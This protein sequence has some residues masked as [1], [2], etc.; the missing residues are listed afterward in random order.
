VALSRDPQWLALRLVQLAVGVVLVLALFVA[1][2]VPFH[3]TDALVYGQASRAIAE[4]GGF[5]VDGVAY[6]AYSRPLFYVTQGWLWWLFGWQEWIGRL[7]SLAFFGLLLWSLFR[8]ARDR[9]LPPLAPWL[10]LLV[11]LAC[12]DAVVQAFAGQTDT[13]VAAVLTFLA[14][15][16]WRWTPSSRTA[17]VVGVAALAAVLAKA[18]ALPA[19]AGLAAACFVGERDGLRDRL[20]FGLAPLVA[21]AAVGLVYGAI[22][23]RHF[24]LALDEFLGGVVGTPAAPTN[25]TASLTHAA[26]TLPV[27]TAAEGIPDRVW[28]GL[29]DFFGSNR[30]SILLR[31][32]WL[33]PYLRMTVLYALAFAIARVAGASHR[34]AVAIAWVLGLAGYVLGPALLSGGQLA[35]DDSAGSIAGSILLLVPLAA[36]AW[37]PVEQQPSRVW[38][39]RLLLLGIPPLLA[40]GVFGILGD[41]RTLSPAWP[42]LFVLCGIVLAAGVAGLAT[43]AAWAAAA[44]VVVL[45]GL[46]ALDFRNFDGLG[47]RPDGSINSLRAFRELTPGTWLHPNQARVA[48]DPQLGGEVEGLRAALAPGARLASN[49]GRMIYYALDRADIGPPPA[50]CADLGDAGALVLLLNMP[51]PFDPTGFACLQP[52]A[53]EAGSYGAWKVTG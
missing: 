53:G 46:A 40:W 13:V 37:C 23:A 2:V 17:I 21:G 24:G 26:G 49:D 35:F 22:M 6:P 48:A 39:G 7:E 38:C 41:T 9:A 36:A 12:P 27:P 28:N 3:A 45:L 44:A 10:T 52:V 16:L 4:H 18:T 29:S 30:D 11:L 15:V 1:L 50:D 42:A 32:E 20:R 8:L 25:A 14:V 33:G 47:A 51:E 5:L 34:L 19:L 43:R 31:G